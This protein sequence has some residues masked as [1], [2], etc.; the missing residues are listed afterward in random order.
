MLPLFQFL[1]DVKTQPLFTAA[2]F[3]ITDLI[4]ASALMKIAESGEAGQSKLY[5]SP[6]RD[7]RSSG[8]VVAAA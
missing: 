2:L 1:P 8:L 6:R 5:T 3:I 7:K 4:G